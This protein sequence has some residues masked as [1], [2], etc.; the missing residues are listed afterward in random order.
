MKAI[1]K[2]G[3]GYSVAGSALLLGSLAAANA[4]VD[5]SAIVAAGTDVGLVGT[6][7]LAVIVAAMAFKWFR[8]AM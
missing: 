8:K 6:A 3:V 4:T 2:R 1:L 5:T 7:V